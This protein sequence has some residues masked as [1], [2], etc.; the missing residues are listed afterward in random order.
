MLGKL[1][2]DARTATG[3]S[4]RDVERLTGISNGYLSQL[5]AGKIK[6]PSP[7]HLFQLAELYGVEYPDLMEAT[8][9]VATES[10]EGVSVSQRGLLRALE[11]LDEGETRRVQEYIQLLRA[12]RS[13]KR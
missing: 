6:Q 5:E 10:S 7:K 1:L 3:K 12:A 2:K 4:L 8:G 11:D 9:Y 13:T